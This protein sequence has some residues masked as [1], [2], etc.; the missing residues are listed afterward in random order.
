MSKVYA[1]WKEELWWESASE[2]L[3]FEFPMGIPTICFPTRAVWD[4]A[5]PAIAA[6]YDAVLRDVRAW[7]EAENV[8]LV[9]EDRTWVQVKKK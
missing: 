7:A 2:W 9:V 1:K 6:D 4:K 8:P 5:S 3:T